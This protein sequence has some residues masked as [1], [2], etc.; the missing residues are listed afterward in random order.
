MSN[1]NLKMAQMA[2]AQMAQIPQYDP[3]KTLLSFIL[4][5]RLLTI[6]VLGSIF[7]FQFIG[8]I[9]QYIINPLLDFVLP[10]E[11]FSFMNLVIRDGISFPKPEPKKLVIDF[12]SF[13]KEF[14]IWI[15]MITILFLMAKY[16]RFPTDLGGN[17]GV[18]I[19]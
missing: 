6:T 1:P 9:K 4:S 7:T 2:Q 18:A 3:Y 14:V 8:S 10:E 16:T 15:F 19:M 11:N 5:E 12:G 17:P 13:F